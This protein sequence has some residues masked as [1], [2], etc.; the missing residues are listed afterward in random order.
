MENIQIGPYQG[1]EVGFLTKHG[2]Q[3]IVQFSLENAL[4]CKLVHTDRYDTD[5]LGTFTRETE[6]TGTQ[7]DAARKKAQKAM[8]LTGA[9]IGLASEGAFGLDPYA[10]LSPWNT[11]L[12]LWSDK[13]RGIEVC[14]IAQGFAQ[15]EH[16]LVSDIDALENFLVLA[17]F[18]DHH[19][20][21]RPEHQEHPLIVK[22]IN[23][24]EQLLSAFARCKATARNGLVFIEND[25]RA[26]SNPTRQAMIAKATE[27][28]V[29]KLLS[30]CP[31]CHN[32][33]YWIK[34]LLPGLPCRRCGRKTRLP[35]AELWHC[36]ACAHSQTREL[37]AGQR[38]DPGG[39]D[40][41]NP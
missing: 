6:R 7:L 14:G 24:R 4:G 29:E 39:C 18:P 37:N 10:G 34:N 22:D 11:E 20:V 36:S 16:K 5:L 21:L 28:L 32:P 23:N 15:S 2:K 33:G 9:S 1:C 35:T 19:V 17:Q 30:H 31:Q 13:D 8:E 25:L 27:N 40:H 38:A 12:V 41:C 26:F 3:H